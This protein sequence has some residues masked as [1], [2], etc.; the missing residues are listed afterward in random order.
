MLGF[1]LSSLLLSLFTSQGLFAADV[2]TSDKHIKKGLYCESCHGAA[3]TAPGAEVSMAKCLSCHGPY[4]KLA[5]GTEETSRNPH[6]YPHHEDLD[7]NVC[8]LGHRADDNYC[9]GCHKK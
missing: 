4:E 6:A 9:G 7:C 1:L 8:N 2:F 3:K 5:K